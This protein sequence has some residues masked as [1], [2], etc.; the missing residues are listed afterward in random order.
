M[1]NLPFS[2]TINVETLFKAFHAIRFF[3]KAFMTMN[4]EV[5]VMKLP[6]GMILEECVKEYECENEE[7]IKNRWID[8]VRI[9]PREGVLENASLYVRFDIE[10]GI[11]RYETSDAA[12]IL[13]ESVALPAGRRSPS[14]IYVPDEC[15]L[16]ALVNSIQD[17][18]LHFQDW[19]LRIYNACSYGCGLQEL[20]NMT[21]GMTPNHIY[22][23]DMSFK[24]LAFTQKDFMREMSATWRFQQEHG[25][26]PVKVMKGLI[27]SGE[28]EQLN[29]FRKAK[30]FYSKNFYVPFVTKNIF[31][32]NKPQAHLF[33]VNMVKRPSY[34]DI[35]IAQIL[36][37]FIE[38]HHFLLAEYKLNRGG[39]NFEAFFNDILRGNPLEVSFIRKQI[40]LFGWS[41]TDSFCLAV[42]GMGGRDTGFINTV[43]YHVENNSSIKCFMYDNYLVMIK[44][45]TDT[46]SGERMRTF[47]E[48]LCISQNMDICV[49]E[50]FAGFMKMKEHFGYLI[51]LMDIS[52]KMGNAKGCYSAADYSI[53]YLADRVTESPRFSY[54]YMKEVDVI[55]D[56]DRDHGTDFEKTYYV[57]LMNDRNIVRA[58][59]I[60]HIHRNTL[61]YRLEKI[62]ELIPFDEDDGLKRLRMLISLILR[63]RKAAKPLDFHIGE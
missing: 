23:S 20:L 33:V 16:F 17:L 51:E 18:F 57:Y 55:C 54:I 58:S 52:Q 8:S 12:V 49:G 15:D 50:Q 34:H 59:S 41:M 4:A 43:I 19:Y 38:Q 11:H 53:F 2:F 46:E 47:L 9:L 56:Y 6:L 3:K 30:H 25:Y 13:H 37:E 29:G 61:Q 48:K 24:I 26:L 35:A 7:D 63:E 36:G 45:V 31:F 60:L 32:N 27:E 1:K 22:I 5:I 62:H 42:S 14:C 39:N 44:A 28:I 10:E 21:A 40:D